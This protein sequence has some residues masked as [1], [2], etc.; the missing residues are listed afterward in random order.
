M[1]TLVINKFY[2]WMSDT[3]AYASDAVCAYQENTDW[4]S[5]PEVLKLN[6]AV[7]TMISTGAG[8]TVAH[9]DWFYYTD[10]G[11]VY[12][13]GWWLEYTLPSWVFYNAIKFWS[14]WIGFYVD[15]GQL[16]LT[17][18]PTTALWAPI[19]WSTV[20]GYGFNPDLS[21][22]APD[23]N[24]H[25]YCVALND[26]EDILYFIGKNTIYTSLVSQ[27]GLMSP[28]IV[29]EKDVVWLTRQGQ[30]IGI[31]LEDGRK[32][33]WDGFSEQHDGYVD[34]GQPIR[35]VFGTR[36]YDYVVAWQAASVYSKLF[37][38]Q[39][40]SFQLIKQG[41]FTRDMAYPGQEIWRHAYWSKVPYGNFTMVAN[42]K[43]V[44][45]TNAEAWS[46]ESYWNKTPW[47]P[48]WTVT[49][50]INSDWVDMW[51]LW[52]EDWPDTIYMSVQDLSWNWSIV[53]LPLFRTPI[54]TYQ[55]E[56]LYYT[57]KYVMWTYKIR[58]TQMVLRYN[59]PTDTEIKI[60]VAV[61]GWD[62]YELLKTISDTEWNI[63]I[64]SPDII[65][66]WYEFQYK[67]EMTTSDP[68]VTP[69]LYSMNIFY[70]QADR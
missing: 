62:T 12:N 14:D 49:E 65:R 59:T 23:L 67:I 46:L 15:W 38:S 51:T 35:Y 7:N 41:Q 66:Q 31:Y 18:T 36:N 17:Q 61:D 34:L 54:P 33:F 10:A 5:Q 39:W 22:F 58:Q 9:I 20:A 30:Q 6:R 25:N 57:K 4:M 16:K 27:P 19:W 63:K 45:I 11:E 28:G 21:P 37:I 32:Y 53:T 8:I 64:A 44:F 70:E 52:F 43:A 24:G 1:A 68:T 47:L 42:E 56:W 40:Q 48:Q 69:S 29:L 50:A 2:W 3:D 13:S 26:S 55:T 60:Y